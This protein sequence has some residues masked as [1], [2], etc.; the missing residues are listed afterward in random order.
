[1]N[2]LGPPI[3]YLALK[4]G[5]PVYDAAGEKVGVVEHVLADA[6]A[7]IFDGLIIHTEPLPGR[8]VFADVDQ[9][10]EMREGGVVLSVGAGELHAPDRDYPSG[11]E[12][13]HDDEAESPL[14]ARL[15]RAFDWIAGRR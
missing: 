3:S 10:A 11:I 7:D 13:E 2:G 6:G 8:H 15:R 4:E 12:T 14:A 9:I 1:M 5:I